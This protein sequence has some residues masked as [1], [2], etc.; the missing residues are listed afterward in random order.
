MIADKDTTKD[1][2]T[3]T[4]FLLTQNEECLGLERSCCV[5]MCAVVCMHTCASPWKMGE[6]VE[7]GWWLREKEP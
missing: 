6:S 2:S 3:A 7:D 4:S 1:K 5:H